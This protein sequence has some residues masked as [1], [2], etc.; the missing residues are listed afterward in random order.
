METIVEPL[1]FPVP[2]DVMSSRQWHLEM[3]ETGIYPD[4]PRVLDVFHVTIGENVLTCV[5]T[6]N[7]TDQMYMYKG[8]HSKEM[9]LAWFLDSL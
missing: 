9:C 7:K 1:R 3:I 2:A 6:S 5:G 8:K 4:G